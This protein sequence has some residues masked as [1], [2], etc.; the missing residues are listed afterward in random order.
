MKIIIEDEALMA[1]V[2]AACEYLNTTP[3][4]FLRL[5][6]LQLNEAR[7]AEAPQT[8]AGSSAVVA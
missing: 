8:D 3:A 4:D 6:I 5:A 7:R 2:V 1:E